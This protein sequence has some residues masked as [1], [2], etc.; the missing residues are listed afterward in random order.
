MENKQLFNSAMQ[1]LSEDCARENGDVY[2]EAVD[3]NDESTTAGEKRLAK[4]SRK[5]SGPAPEELYNKFVRVS[6]MNTSKF[7]DAAKAREDRTRT[8]RKKEREE[9]EVF[10]MKKWKTVSG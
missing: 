8:E 3:N 4:V 7:V 9:Q 2:A 10:E 1:K 5:A 6:E